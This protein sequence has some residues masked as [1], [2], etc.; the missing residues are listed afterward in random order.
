M[1][2]KEKKFNDKITQ[3][4]IFDYKMKEIGLEKKY[5]GY[6]FLVEI[7]SLIINKKNEVKS[8]SGEIYPL[9]AKKFL[10]SES[11]IERNVRSVI[12]SIWS[13]DRKFEIEKTLNLEKK[14]TCCEF[15]YALKNY[16]VNEIA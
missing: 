1:F 8:F 10:T 7:M 2:T 3:N 5:T 12:A 13:C 14:P 6:Y 9:V 15:I 4:L 16:I 11:S